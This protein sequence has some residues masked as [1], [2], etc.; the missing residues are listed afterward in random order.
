MTPL[1]ARSRVPALPK[2]RGFTLASVTISTL[3]AGVVLTGAWLGFSDLQ[4]QWRVSNADR[5][6]DQYAASTMQELTNTLSWAWGAKQIQGG[7]RDPHWKFYLDDIIEENGQMERSRWDQYY[8][9]ASDR[10]LELTYRPTGGI[11]FNN[12][13]PKWAVDRTSWYVWVGRAGVPRGAT[14]AYDRRDRM[15]VEGLTIDF[16]RFPYLPNTTGL[17]EENLRR[18]EVVT[19]TMVM[20]YSYNAPYWFQVGT[21]MYGS[22]YVRERIYST[23]IAM[24]NWDVESNYFRDQVLGLAPDN[25]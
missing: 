20:H 24:R 5:V 3:I 11:Y 10:L 19:V 14:R 25:G 18:S 16:N 1:S 9:I 13:P 17:P 6:M 22:R 12:T 4:V 7:S 21:R 15:T 23:Q 8:H 2:Q